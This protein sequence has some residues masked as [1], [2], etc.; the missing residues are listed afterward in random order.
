M[1]G[2]L[3]NHPYTVQMIVEHLPKS[4]RVRMMF[5][6]SLYKNNEIKIMQLDHVCAIPPSE[7]WL[8]F[9]LPEQMP[10]IETICLST[11][12]VHAYV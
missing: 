11:V 6:K 9:S 4:S 1:E 12:C 5:Q 10:G 8:H 3:T 2:L 7:M